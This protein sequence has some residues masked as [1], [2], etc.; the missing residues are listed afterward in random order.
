MLVGPSEKNVILLADLDDIVQ[1][2]EDWKDHIRIK[3]N[4]NGPFAFLNMDHKLE[5]VDLDALFASKPS[6]AKSKK[7]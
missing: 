4:G 6:E 7:S 3:D 5:R 1:L 2:G